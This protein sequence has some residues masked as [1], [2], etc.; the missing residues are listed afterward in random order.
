MDGA[1]RGSG[2]ELGPVG[3]SAKPVQV[4][5]VVWLVG[6]MRCGWLVGLMRCGVVG[7]FNEVWCGWLV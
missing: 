4:V 7:W 5:P 2:C 1:Q 6:L 3:G